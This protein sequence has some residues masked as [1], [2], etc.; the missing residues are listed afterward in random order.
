VPSPNSS[1]PLASAYSTGQRTSGAPTNSSLSGL[2]GIPGP[3]T[4][5]SPSTSHGGSH[6]TSHGPGHGPSALAW[7]WPLLRWSG[8]TSSL[9]SRQNK[10]QTS[11]Y[12][13]AVC[14]V[15]S[16]L[17]RCLSGFFY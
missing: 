12:T 13:G 15:E 4:G 5:V 14:Y 17:K 1:W 8:G 2:T 3:V 16:V 6:G 11:L 9:G 10:I 7:Q